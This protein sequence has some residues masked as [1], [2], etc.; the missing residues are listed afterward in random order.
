MSSLLVSDSGPLIVFAIAGLIPQLMQLRGSVLVPKAVLQECLVRPAK[1]GY[2][3][4]QEALKAGHLLEIESAPN[5]ITSHSSTNLG[6]GE[7][8]VLSL[9]KSNDYIAVIDEV[10]ARK[11]AKLMGIRYVG[12]GGLLLEL[13][14][15][16]LVSAIKPI[17]DVWA[18][19]DYF[20]SSAI[21]NSLLEIAQETEI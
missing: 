11:L 13:K 10:R 9:C 19:H 8:A 16:K 2:R 14:R 21:R 4:I 18:A 20:I 6:D 17:L 7:L 5:L 1:P 3:E 15:A 12:S